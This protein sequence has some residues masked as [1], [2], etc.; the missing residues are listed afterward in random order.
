MPFTEVRTIKIFSELY[1]AYFRIVSKL[2]SEHAITDSEVYSIIAEDGFRDTGLF[3]TKKLMPQNDGS[4]WGL[5]KRD[6]VGVLHPVTVSEPPH[7]L[8]TLQK[9]W[10]RSKLDDPRLCLFLDDRELKS[11][12]EK[13]ADVPPLYRHDI[14]RYVDKYSDGDPFTKTDYRKNFRAVLSALK[15]KQ[16]IEISY[17]SKTGKSIVGKFLPYKLEYSHRDDKFRVFCTSALKGSVVINL[18]RI[19]TVSPAKSSAVIPPPDE[20]SLRC[21]EPIE[22]TVSKECRADERFLMEFA[23]YEK[24]TERI[25]GS[26]KVSVKLWYDKSDETDLLVRLLGFGPVLEIKGPQEIRQK[27]AERIRKQWKLLHSDRK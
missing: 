6:K 27:A 11:L 22:L 10:L 1:G 7:I 5:F 23:P 13:V 14:F 25:E 9:R 2:L 12:C 4:D 26:D 16:L 3:L 24:R 20:N 17:V 8:T 19:E 15:Q 21:D 18:A